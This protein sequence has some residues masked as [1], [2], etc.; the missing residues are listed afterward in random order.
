MQCVILAGGLGTRLWPM[1]Q[2]LPKS[3]IPIN[4]R[5]FADYQL[6][7][8]SR[9]GI[10]DVIYCIGYLGA[11]IR[12]AIG[13]GSRFG[14]AVRYADEGDDLKGT[15]G[16]LR[17]ALDAR[18]LA[19]TFCVLY[20]DSFLPVQFAPIIAA[21]RA[22]GCRAL[23]T[24]MRNENRWDTSN[25]IFA[26][27][28]VTLYDKHCDEATRAG[29]NYIDYGLSVLTRDLIA[30]EIPPGAKTDL[31]DLLKRMSLAGELAGFEIADR[32]YEIGSPSGIAE[33]SQFVERVGL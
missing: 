18:L 19:E 29:M 16:A 11:Q 30:Q 9:Q 17:G 1:T 32:F 33:F 25:A 20:G 5:P 27:P 8:L 7:W 12:E 28:F 21:F 15:G 22:S 14:V 10:T 6:T 2:V 31:A 3:L 24:V 26:A 4:G 23:M 13:E